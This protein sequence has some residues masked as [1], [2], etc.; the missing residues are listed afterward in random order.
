MFTVKI[1]TTQVRRGLL[2][3]GKQVDEGTSKGLNDAA[4]GLR[5]LWIDD[6]TQNV[7]DPTGF[8]KKVF[9]K[10]SFPDT[11]ISKTLI[12]PIQSRYLSK[13]VAGGV[14][15]IGDYATLTTGS[16]V[17]VDAKL[18][19]YGN[20]PGGPKRW[21][22][23]SDTKLNAFVI[24]LKGNKSNLGVFQRTKRKLKLLAVIKDDVQYKETLPLDKTVSNFANEAEKII[25]S[26]I[27]KA[28][29]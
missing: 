4:F 8:T 20:F 14:R 24:P 22:A 19:V 10:K 23:S 13:I 15:K 7:D 16:L 2:N 12:P 25:S 18:N 11:L 5:Q 27:V 3:L 26:A 21:I 29:G 9:V 6:I 1:D 28:I 17:P